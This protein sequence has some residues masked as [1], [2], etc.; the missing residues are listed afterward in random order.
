MENSTF[1]YAIYNVLSCSLQFPVVM[2]FENSN[3]SETNSLMCLAD[4]ARIG[5]GAGG[6]GAHYTG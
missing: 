6:A 1:I 5:G 4:V 2:F 3:T